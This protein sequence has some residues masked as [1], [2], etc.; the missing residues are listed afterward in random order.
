MLPLTTLPP[1]LGYTSQHSCYGQEYDWW[2]QW[3]YASPL[4]ET[5]SLKILAHFEGGPKC[6][7]SQSTAFGNICEGKKDINAHICAHDLIPITLEMI[8]PKVKKF[9]PMFP[10][11]F[12]EFN[13]LQ[14]AHKDA[15]G[16]AFKSKQFTLYIVVPAAQWVEYEALMEKKDSTTITSK[17]TSD[18]G[19]TSSVHVPSTVASTTTGDMINMVNWPFHMCLA[20]T[21]F[22]P[23]WISA[24]VAT[25]DD[26]PA[27]TH[28]GVIAMTPAA[29]LSILRPTSATMS[30][31]RKT[32][33]LTPF[34]SPSWTELQEAL[35]SSGTSEL[36]VNQV[37]MQAFETMQFYP[38]PTQQLM[39]ILGNPQYCSFDLELSETYP[40]RLRVNQSPRSFIG[41]GVF[42]TAQSG[43]LMLTPPS[44]S[45]LG[46]EVQE[47]VIVKHPFLWPPVL[48]SMCPSLTPGHLLEIY[49]RS[50][51]TLYWAN[52]L[53]T[54]TYDFIDGVISSADTSPPFN[55]PHL[56]FVNAGLALA[57]SQLTKGLS[58]PKFGGTL[59]SV[60]L[61]EEKIE[62]GSDT[63]IKYIH[64]MDCGLSLS[65]DMDGYDIAE[66]L[67]FT[68]HVQ[69]AKSGGLVIVLDYQGSSTLLT[70]PQ[71]LADLLVGDGL[72]VF[73]EGNVKSTVASF[74]KHHKCNW[75]CKWPGFA[76]KQFGAMTMTT[77]ESLST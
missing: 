43:L 30:P 18:N 55:I 38:I 64:N 75:F 47:N 48:Y 68:Q 71:I 51:N 35:K 8:I 33:M 27:D 29:N 57:H 44:L 56:H 14:P 54:M 70:D 20:Q 2:A 17:D 16:M 7:H 40:S 63:F 53:L 26:E 58:K 73:S 25:P 12:D 69:Y 60:Y 21:T 39:E 77:H 67:A 11:Q 76:L 34:M 49:L 24:Q 32:P 13:C 52:A 4:A 61:L 6:G 37:L 1:C 42:K 5:I 59:C 50:A 15:R 46:S 41:I 66:F 23:A 3:T 19:E 72:D 62:G 9:C 45:S 65:M 74:E 22:M 31:P 36:N 10:W 28:D